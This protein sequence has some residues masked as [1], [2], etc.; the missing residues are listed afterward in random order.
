MSKTSQRKYDCKKRLNQFYEAGLRG[1]P[2]PHPSWAREE[3]AKYLKGKRDGGF[4]TYYK[5]KKKAATGRLARLVSATGEW[6]RLL[7]A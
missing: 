3:R 4:T 5:P 6:I 2:P 1:E 7:M